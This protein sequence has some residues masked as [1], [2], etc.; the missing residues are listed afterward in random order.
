MSH[1]KASK[2]EKIYAIE[3]DKLS[4]LLERKRLRMTLGREFVLKETLNAHGHFSAEDLVKICKDKKVKVSRATIYRTLNELLEANVIRKTAF[5]DKH[6][7]F[8]HLYDER[9]HHHAYCIKTGKYFE[10]PDFG[11]EKKY[12]PI[13]EKMGFKVLGHELHFYGISKERVKKI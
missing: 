9:P 3:R 13:L 7:N 11:E 2:T 1:M 8:E 4:E 12:L 5:G 6:S 10:L